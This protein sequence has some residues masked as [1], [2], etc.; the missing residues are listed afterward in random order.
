MSR[1]EPPPYV[2]QADRGIKSIVARITL[3]DYAAMRRL[4]HDDHLTVQSFLSACVDAY[5]RRET[6]MVNV[7][8]EYRKLIEVSQDNVSGSHMSKMDKRALFDEI[9]MLHEDET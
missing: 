1:K 4:L 5:V 8:E 3:G 7:V 9:E 2:L 6:T